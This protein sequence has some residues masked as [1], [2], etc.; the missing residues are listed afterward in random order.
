[1]RNIPDVAL[2]ADDVWVIY[3]SGLSNSFI[4]TSCAA[5]LWAGFIALVNQQA[6]LPPVGFINPA[7]YA[8]GNGSSYTSCFHK[9]TTGNNTWPGSPDKYYPAAGYDL[10]T[11]WGTPNGRNLI[12]ALA[13]SAPPSI[14]AQPQSQSV[15]AGSSVTFNVTAVGY[16]PLNIQWF[17]GG[18]NVVNGG[19]FQIVNGADVGGVD[20]ST[21]TISNVVITDSGNY[22]V[23][24]TNV[25]SSIT[26]SASLAEFVG[27]FFWFWQPS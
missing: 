1:M 7:I 18:S 15:V 11:G 25:V 3:D 12:N 16:T 24:V 27:E 2:T 10:C 9:T 4:G 8:I 17:D 14:Q 13:G 21:L 22:Y 6:V 19:R 23:V 5:P 26:S 20:T